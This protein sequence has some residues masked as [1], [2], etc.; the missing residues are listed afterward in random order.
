MCIRDRFIDVAKHGSQIINVRQYILARDKI[1]LTMATNYFSDRC[2]VKKRI[3]GRDAVAI[4][5]PCGQ[6]R[7][8]DT[9][10]RMPARLERL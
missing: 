1:D 9:A 7:G 10:H 5:N 8:I 2:A 3:D 4:G 6:R